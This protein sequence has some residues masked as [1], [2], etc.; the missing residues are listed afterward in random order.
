[1]SV[2]SNFEL[3]LVLFLFLFLRVSFSGACASAFTASRH[4]S[5]TTRDF[6]S[7]LSAHVCARF[8][9]VQVTFEE[10]ACAMAPRDECHLATGTGVA[11]T[12]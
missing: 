8:E 1:M 7:R 2:F 6:V 12:T 10:R 4:V 5:S 11:M 3:L 9:Y